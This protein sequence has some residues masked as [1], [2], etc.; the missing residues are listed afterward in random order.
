[1][2][3]Q[4]I[5]PNVLAVIPARSGSKGLRDKNIAVLGGHPLLAWSI[6]VCRRSDHI[7]KICVSTD[8]V[9]YAR[10]AE[11]NGIDVPF[12]RPESISGD[13]ATDLQFLRHV[14]AELSVRKYFPDYIVHIRP[15]TPFRDPAVIDRAIEVI[16]DDDQATSLRSVHEMSES[17]YKTFEMDDSFNLRSVM[18]TNFG[19]HLDANANRQMFPRTYAANGYVDVLRPV[20]LLNND[21]I[22]GGFVRGFLTNPVIEIDTQYDFNLAQAIL[23]TDHSIFNA[24]F[25]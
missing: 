11:E 8:S 20:Q 13:S 7:N 19:F 16:L 3:K 4:K 12:L 22:H 9:V 23:S 1:M 2:K 14:M 5:R 24:V 10:I 25:K 18:A 15:T 17:A 21:S 6:A